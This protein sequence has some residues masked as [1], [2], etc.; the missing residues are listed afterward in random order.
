MPSKTFFNLKGEK[1]ERIEK[2]LVHEFSKGSFEQASITNIIK[3]AGIPRGSFYQ[4]FED[5]KDAVEYL[6]GKF[7]LIDYENVYQNLIASKGNIFE[8]ALKVY[9]YRTNEAIVNFDIGLARN[10]LEELRKNN[11]NL[12]EKTEVLKNKKSLTELIDKTQ[13][14]LESEED[15]EYFIKILTA[16]IRNV[17]I[18]VFSGRLPKDEGRK[19]LERELEIIKKGMKK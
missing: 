18:E 10:I 19:I 15:L 8:T 11:I 17:T 3:K 2:A 12:F 1:R 14:N 5:K 16:I 4:Y 13:L 6:I 9:N 7:I